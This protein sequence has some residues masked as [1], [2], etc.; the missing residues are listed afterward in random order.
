MVGNTVYVCDVSKTT[1]SE[2]DYHAFTSLYQSFSAEG[3]L[4]FAALHIS[5]LATGQ[6]AAAVRSDGTSRQLPSCRDWNS[7]VSV[8]SAPVD[9]VTSP[10][11]GLLADELFI[12]Y[13]RGGGDRTNSPRVIW[14]RSRRPRRRASTL[15]G[16]C[17]AEFNIQAGVYLSVWK[18]LGDP[19]RCSFPHTGSLDEGDKKRK[20][21]ESLR[22]IVSDSVQA[23]RL[24]FR[25]T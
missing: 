17:A 12:L 15:P 13:Q 18:S 6:S 9:R 21:R 8:C 16:Q 24:S 7:E 2:H 10:A 11:A 4:Y 19:S 23:A 5:P 1:P 14:I 3:T 25:C 20:G 22:V